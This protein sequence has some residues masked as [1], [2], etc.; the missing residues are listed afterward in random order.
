MPSN[1]LF[2]V[3]SVLADAYDSEG[4]VS[5]ALKSLNLPAAADKTRFYYEALLGRSPETAALALGDVEDKAETVKSFLRSK[6]FADIHIKLFRNF[7]PDR[8]A[9]IFLHIPKTGGTTAI[10]SMALSGKFVNI[11]TPEHVSLHYTNCL[12]YYA[13]IFSQLRSSKK[14]FFVLGHPSASFV[15]D[16]ALKREGDHIFTFI[17]DPYE[18]IISWINYSLTLAYKQAK[19]ESGFAQ[20][21]DA[22]EVRNVIGDEW[23]ASTPKISED[24]IC[25]VIQNIIFDNPI[26]QT[27]GAKPNFISAIDT[28]ARL[29]IEVS[30]LSDLK[31]F[32]QRNGFPTPDDQNVSIKFL[33]R[34]SVTRKIFEMIHGKISEDYKFYMYMKETMKARTANS[35]ETAQF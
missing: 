15:I 8:S 7:F 13:E 12:L 26:C 27:L 5:L 30:F 6:E 21:V 9:S 4:D 14:D 20:R 11:Q 3:L 18:L 17:R 10:N 25:Q 16:G 24:L 33:N 31:P 35:S 29:N 34:E 2:D 22:Q 32:L 1:V 19:Q 28:C 23:C